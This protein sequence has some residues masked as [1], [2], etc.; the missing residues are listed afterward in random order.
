MGLLAVNMFMQ[1]I[2]GLVLSVLFTYCCG[3]YECVKVV[4]KKCVTTGYITL[5]MW[6]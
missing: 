3:L 4:L 5:T 2:E 1:I 6:S